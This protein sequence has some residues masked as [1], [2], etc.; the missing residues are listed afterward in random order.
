MQGGEPRVDKDLLDVS[1][2]VPDEE[3][4]YM[5][6]DGIKDNLANF[7]F[8]GHDTSAYTIAMVARMLQHNPQCLEGVIKGSAT[9][10]QRW[11]VTY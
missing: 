4:K 10:S 5:S 2:S 3:G 1:L 8:A 7:L 6:D 11:S 9:W